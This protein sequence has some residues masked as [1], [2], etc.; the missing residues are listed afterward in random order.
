MNN[1]KKIILDSILGLRKNLNGRVLKNKNVSIISNNCWGGYMCQFSGIQYNS[2]FVGLFFYAEDY[3]RLLLHIDTIYKPFVFKKREESKFYK[4]LSEK[5]YPIGYWPDIDVEIHFLHF[6]NE[7]E[8]IE[9]WN[10][11]LERFDMSNLIVKFCDKELC[12]ED[13]I[14]EFDRLPFLNKVCF[15]SK[16][17]PKYSS[18]VWLKEQSNLDEVDHCWRISDKYWNFVE[19]A[20]ML[21]GANTSFWGRLILWMTSRIKLD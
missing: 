2:P 13:M 15:T 21:I 6:K 11:R 9:K 12:T 17:Y 7:K 16:P 5:N 14:N 4:V 20:N 19:N 10:R 3:I 8:C 18:V 1:I